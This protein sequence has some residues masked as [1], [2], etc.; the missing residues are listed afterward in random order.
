MVLK[1]HARVA[2]I[3]FAL[4]PP[5]PKSWIRHWS[6]GPFLFVLNMPV[7]DCCKLV[8]MKDG[9]ETCCANKPVVHQEDLPTGVDE[10]W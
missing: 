1:F 2:L 3:A 10:R 5:F 8:L 9:E 4:E 6:G 7:S